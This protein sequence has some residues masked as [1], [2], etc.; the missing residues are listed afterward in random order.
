M[1]EK[2]LSDEFIPCHDLV[3]PKN[4]LEAC[5]FDTCRSINPAASLCRAIAEYT[6]ACAAVGICIE[7]WRTDDFCREYCYES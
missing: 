3:D 4:Y 5:R 7:D 6:R 1:C 2:L